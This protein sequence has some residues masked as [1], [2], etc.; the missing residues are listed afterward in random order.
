MLRDHTNTMLKTV[1]VGGVA[2]GASAAA[3]A[4]RLN[5]GSPILVL[6]KGPYVSFANCGLPYHIGGEIQDREKLLVQTPESFAQRFNVEVRV[7]N[8]V[9]GIDRERRAVKVKDHATGKVY[10]EGYD[11]LVLSTGAKPVV[12]P[13]PGVQT[14]YTFTLRDIT[15]MDAIINA[16]DETNPKH[17]TI[18]GGGFIGLEMAESLIRRGVRT[19]ILELNPQVMGPLDAEMASYLHTELRANGVDL[20]LGTGL[21]EVCEDGSEHRL[22]LTCSQS[23]TLGTDLLLVCIGVRPDAKLAREAGLELGSTGGVRVTPEM[24]SSDENIYAVGDV[25]EVIDFVSG[26][27]TLVPLAGPANRQGRIAASNIMGT[28]L[29]YNKTQGTAICK[30][31]DMAAGCTGLAEKTLVKKGIAY[32]KVYLHSGSHA[33]YYPHSQMIH[34]KLLFSPEGKILGAQ[35]VG[36]DGVDKR[37]DVLATAQRAGMTVYDL[38]DLELCYAP[39][40]GSAKDIVNLAGFV[41]SNVLRGDAAICHCKDVED[42]S[43]DQFLLDVRNAGEVEQGAIP[44]ATNIP[45]DSLRDRH[46]EL[47]RN[48]E[49]LLY[50]MAGLRGHVAAR[51]LTNMGY[52]VKNLSGGY[53]TWKATHTH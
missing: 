29:E 39:P 15:D 2:G 34:L 23:T 42:P 4:R 51:M 45:L 49:I 3:R 36:K 35:A 37:I 33:G 30:V 18:V 17:A 14:P 44:T 21:A 20:R 50:C 46:A 48:K 25:V 26:D 28:P 16:L 31:F 7:N 8:E 10:E 9:L 52:R 47:P 6:E 53:R 19:T 11:R 32:E 12:P 1:I 41:A 13:I 22:R 38:E 5:E 27:P 40:Y 24:R 43:P